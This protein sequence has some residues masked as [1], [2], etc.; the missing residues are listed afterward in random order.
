MKAVIFDMDG[1]LVDVSRAY[2]QAI[3]QAT[4]YFTGEEIDPKEIQKLKN[5][6]GFNDDIDLTEALISIR[7]HIPNREKVEKKFDELYEKLKVGEKWLLK[8]EILRK[9]F[10]K[11]KMGIVTGRPRKDAEYALKRS[12]AEKFFQAVIT[13]EDIPENKKKP[14]SYGLKLAIEKL[15]ADN[16]FYFGDNI[17]DMKMA[18]NANVTPIGVLPPGINGKTRTLLEENGAKIVLDDINGM[19][20]VI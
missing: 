15:Q 9:L 20:G 1:V 13:A 7:G 10:M 19:L 14:D 8:L 17:D 16:I 6:G 2:R 4:E 12:G 5:Q 11:Y 18:V 3:K